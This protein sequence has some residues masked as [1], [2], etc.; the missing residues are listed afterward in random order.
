[1]TE[2]ILRCPQLA[3]RQSCPPCDELA[4]LNQEVSEAERGLATLNTNRLSIYG[5]MNR[6]H[7]PLTSKLPTE[8]VSEIF[9]NV[10][11]DAIVSLYYLG[12]GSCRTMPFLLGSVCVAW[13]AI[14]WSTPRLWTSISLDLAKINE[15]HV[16]VVRGW[17]RRSGGCPLYIHI[18][19]Q[20]HTDNKDL[21][22]E[23]L[24]LFA[25]CS[26]HWFFLALNVPVKYLPRINFAHAVMLD[27]LRIEFEKFADPTHHML[28]EEMNLEMMPGLRKLYMDVFPTSKLVNVDW[29]KLRELETHFPSINTCVETFS[30][31][32]F[33]THCALF[34]THD[35]TNNG[36]VLTQNTIL[37]HNHLFFLNI[38]NWTADMDT[39]LKM[40]QLPAL[41][42]LVVAS[43]ED[44][45]INLVTIG[46]L[47]RRSRC[48]LKTLEIDVR[49]RELVGNVE[50][51]VFLGGIPSLE[52]MELTREAIYRNAH[53]ICDSIDVFLILLSETASTQS[54]PIFLPNLKKLVIKHMELSW[55]Y[56]L[57]MLLAHSKSQKVRPLRSVH[58]D[59]F[60]KKYMSMETDMV[61][62]LQDA[63]E[64]SFADVM[65]VGG[66]YDSRAYVIFTDILANSLHRLEPELY[67]RFYLVSAM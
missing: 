24:D 63:I 33:L 44:T 17:L 26:D 59:M 6:I 13:R 67:S 21:E 12:S 48:S 30:N 56:V 52:T 43:L 19:G 38:I 34:I 50:L 51:V 9:T 27:T 2:Y 32:S 23:V 49:S 45:Q 65:I 58:L 62:K 15:C 25:Q 54:R 64:D 55:N 66:R 5:R 14:A 28:G 20:G 8:I 11:P 1:M 16:D 10:L 31:A 40:V 47:L 35:F 46:D 4:V 29:N 53:N 61:Q 36:M 7:D 57:D 3:K 22:E 60:G 42:H 41:Q 39:F 37:Q 18:Y